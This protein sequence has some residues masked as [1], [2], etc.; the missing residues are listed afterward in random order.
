ML[1]LIPVF[2]SRIRIEE[3]L[4]TEEFGDVYRTYKAATK[5]LVPFIY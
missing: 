4:L 5:K 1:G 3:K 2:L